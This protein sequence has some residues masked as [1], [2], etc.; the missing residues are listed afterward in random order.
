MVKNIIIIAVCLFGFTT[1]AQ[2]LSIGLG[3]DPKMALVGPYKDKPN[4][5]GATLDIELSFA[6]NWE[7]WRLQT[8]YKIHPAIGFSKWT[9]FELDYKLNNV[10]LKNFTWYLGAEL[11][12]IRRHS[13][14]A[15]F[16][17]PDNYIKNETQGFQPGVSTQLEWR[18]V[19]GRFGLFIEFSAY[20]AERKL[21][22]YKK[23]RK[24]VTAGLIVY[25]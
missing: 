24:D 23:L 15:S 11:S 1:T 17:Q 22:K 8:A 14:D 13:D 20:Q 2:E 3:I 18:M 12:S 9:Y 10:I 6:L 25:L 19:D 16:D 7:K 4:D 21:Y 5:I